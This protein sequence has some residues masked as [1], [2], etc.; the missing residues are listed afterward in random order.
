MNMQ[1]E[2]HVALV[3][4]GTR[5]IGHA[6]ACKLATLGAEVIVTGRKSDGAEAVPDFCYIPVDFS[7]K[8]QLESF[9]AQVEQLQGLSILVNN[10]GLNRIHTFDA[11]PLQDYEE[12]QQVNLHAPYRVA[13]AAARNMLAA[14]CRGRI[15][16]IA[17]IWAT[18]TKPG[19]SGYCTAKAGLLGMTRAMATDLAYAGILV[20]ALSPGFIETQL[21]LQTLGEEGMREMQSAIPL[22]RLGRPEEI[23]EFASFLVG[24]GNT[25]MTGQNIIVDGG[26][27]NV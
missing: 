25:Y 8:S 6:I 16:N 27:T 24:P 12:L 19:R 9:A 21:T 1:L 10:A 22:G 5:G 20:N 15:L 11:F 7:D 2:G 4:G 18:H 26:F 17:S 14:D 13:Q 3:T 23:A